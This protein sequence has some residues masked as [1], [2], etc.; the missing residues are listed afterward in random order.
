M[1]TLRVYDRLISLGLNCETSFNLYKFY[2]G[3]ESSLFQWATV[4]AANFIEVLENPTLIYSGKIIEDPKTNMWKCAVTHI[5]FHGKSLP[6]QLLD[7]HGQRDKEKV[8]AEIKDTVKRVHYLC[9]KF[10]VIAQSAET[11]LYII[12]LHPA[13]YTDTQENTVHFLQNLYTVL[14][15]TAK[16]AS[17]LVILE[18][19]MK[20]PEKMQMDNNATFF[21]RSIDHFAPAQKATSPEEMDMQGYARIFQEFSPAKFVKKEKKYKFEYE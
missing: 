21:I 12:G 18:D 6:C 8:R 11:K 10:R 1:D 9:D 5:N 13:F 17:L 3:T 2:G 16:N 19:K 4:P 20:T 14:Q 15:H 7:E